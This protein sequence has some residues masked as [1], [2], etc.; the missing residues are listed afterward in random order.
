MYLNLA[1][2]VIKVV[3]CVYIKYIFTKETRCILPGNK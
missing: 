1:E 3:K 2:K